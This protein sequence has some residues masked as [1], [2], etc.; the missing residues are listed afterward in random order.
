MCAS[1]ALAHAAEAD[2]GREAMRRMVFTQSEQQLELPDLP[3][4]GDWADLGSR[5]DS[6]MNERMEV[7]LDHP[8]QTAV[9]LVC[10]QPAHSWLD[11]VRA[12]VLGTHTGGSKRGGRRQ[13]QCLQRRR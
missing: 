3:A 6:V 12:A 7:R 11:V 1:Q 9:L 5:A 4:S 2:R 10:K 13:W 8:F